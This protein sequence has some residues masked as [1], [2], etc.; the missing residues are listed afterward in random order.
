[1]LILKSE[2]IAQA[3][4]N[5]VSSASSATGKRSHRAQYRPF[6]GAMFFV[7]YGYFFL[8]LP[9]REKRELKI[10]LSLVTLL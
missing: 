10:S 8:P 1:V 4:Q 2:S 6:G 3:V 9:F 5:L 7:D